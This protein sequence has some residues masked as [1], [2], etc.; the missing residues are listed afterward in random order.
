MNAKHFL[1]L[2]GQSQPTLNSAVCNCAGE[3]TGE[4]RDCVKQVI[5]QAKNFLQNTPLGAGA[6]AL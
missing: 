2:R 1:H 3:P 4:P 6:V 5:V